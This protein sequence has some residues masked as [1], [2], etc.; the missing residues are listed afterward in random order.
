MN[1]LIR[2]LVKAVINGIIL[3]PFLIWFSGA[4]LLGSMLAAVGLTII[5]YLVGDQLILRAT[6]NVIAT[7]ADA[8]LAFVYLWMVASFFHWTLRPGSL[9]FTIVALAIGEL[10]YHGFLQLY[11]RTRARQS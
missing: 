10:F 5:A 9:L 4:S 2:L 6:N 1:H 11:D 8:F 7:V 3:V